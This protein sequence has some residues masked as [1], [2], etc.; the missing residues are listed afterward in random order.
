MS[1][2]KKKIRKLTSSDLEAGLVVIK[3]KPYIAVSPGLQIECICCGKGLVKVKCP[4]SIRDIV[5]SV[6]NLKYLEMIG[7]LS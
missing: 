4:Y 3:E 7:K 1:V 2:T 5:P 6:E